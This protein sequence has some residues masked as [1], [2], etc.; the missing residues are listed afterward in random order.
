[1]ALE[2]V[3][4]KNVKPESR[5]ATAS[6]GRVVWVMSNPH[7]LIVKNECQMNAA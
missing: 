7:K 6:F 5:R 4:A 1:V 2:L 3:G